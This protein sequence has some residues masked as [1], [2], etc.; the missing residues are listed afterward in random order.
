MSVKNIFTS[1]AFTNILVNLNGTFSGN[2][3]LFIATSKQSP[4]SI[5]TIFPV[6]LYSIILEG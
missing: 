3:S 4:K 1:I 6:Y 2:L 5:C